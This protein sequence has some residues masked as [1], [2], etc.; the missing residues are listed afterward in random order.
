LLV[1]VAA[2]CESRKIAFS[3]LAAAH[4]REGTVSAPSATHQSLQIP[5]A[6]GVL[7]AHLGVPRESPRGA[8]LFAHSSGSGRHSPRNRYVADELIGAGLVTVLADLLIREEEQ[9]DLRTAVLRFDIDLLAERVTALADRK[10]H[11]AGTMADVRPHRRW[12]GRF[13]D[14]ESR[15]PRAVAR[16]APPPQRMERP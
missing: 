16:A 3:A 5:F 13:L 14:Q 2:L 9:V 4:P 10:A 12:H 6:G 15:S 8:V 1:C 11:P 7:A